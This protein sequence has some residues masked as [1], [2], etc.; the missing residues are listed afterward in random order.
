MTLNSLEV[1][2]VAKT[3][4][5]LILYICLQIFQIFT[6]FIFR[7]IFG[8]TCYGTTVLALSPATKTT[9]GATVHY[10]VVMLL[11]RC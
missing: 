3:I 7:I 2:N 6:F 8:R 5:F 11:I 9:S 10:L 1:K 4:Y